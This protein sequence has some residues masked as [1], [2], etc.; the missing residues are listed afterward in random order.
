MRRYSRLALSLALVVVAAVPARAEGPYQAQ[1][2]AAATRFGLD[3][4]L[5]EAVIRA[6]SG[7][8]PRAVSRAGA[9][10]LMQ[11]MPRTWAELR[12]RLAL[13]PDPF[14]PGD[15]ILAG[16]AYLRALHDR[17]GAPG[18][19]AAYNAGPARY[20]ASLAG[21]SL[22]P[23]TH[24][25]VGRVTSGLATLPPAADWRSAGLF[26]SAWPASLGPATPAWPPGPGDVR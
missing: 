20:E 3:P 24:A 1:I 13:G 7:G 22:P 14:S 17:Y 2:A 8:D 21:R 4:R 25:Y 15:N 26:P 5:I 12:E 11:L 10:G 19:L 16:A 6:E 18:F 23:E 9:M